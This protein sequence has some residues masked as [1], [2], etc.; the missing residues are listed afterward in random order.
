MSVIYANSSVH[1]GGGAADDDDGRSN[2]YVAVDFFVDDH[3]V[4]STALFF[5][6]GLE[7]DELPCDDQRLVT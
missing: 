7:S 5:S 3:R 4:K 6:I 2:V 1:G